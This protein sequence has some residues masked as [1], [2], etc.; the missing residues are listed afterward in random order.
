VMETP[1]AALRIVG[2]VSALVGVAL[3]WLVRG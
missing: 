2:I 1:D 3:I